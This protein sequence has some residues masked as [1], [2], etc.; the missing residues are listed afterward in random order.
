MPIWRD[1]MYVK[2][3]EGKFKFI[4]GR[5]AQFTQNG[6]QN[7]AVL[8][9]LIHENYLWINTRIAQERGIAFGDTVEVTSRVG[10]VKIKAYLT[11]E[12]AP[13][14]LFFVHGFGAQSE[15]L[16]GAY[17]NGAADNT[18]IEDII[19]PYFGAAAMHA[20]IVDVRKV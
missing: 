9:D 11:E 20:T 2:T 18:I 8:L 6:T 12:I 17:H 19:E 4:T 14:N 16:S 13:D 15:G 3:P 10:S 5:H 1:E 7:N